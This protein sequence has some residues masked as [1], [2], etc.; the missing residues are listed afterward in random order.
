MPVSNGKRAKGRIG[1]YSKAALE[2][3]DDQI[4]KATSPD[5]RRRLII[6]KGQ[7]LDELE[8]HDRAV[9]CFRRGIAAFVAVNDRQGVIECWSHIAQVMG[10]TKKRKEER[11]ADEKVLNLIGDGE[12]GS[13]F[14]PMTLTMLA[15]LEIFDK[16]FDEA[17]KLLDR[18]ERK[19]EK[20]LNPMVLFLVQDLRS[21]LPP[22]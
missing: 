8:E 12:D 6:S 18:A 20:L 19:N 14:L 9:G 11:E 10:K 5:E 22:T 7:S 4:D 16:R 21:K 17:R 3:I 13:F 15:Q 2:I 1:T